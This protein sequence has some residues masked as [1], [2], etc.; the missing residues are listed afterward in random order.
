[1]DIVLITGANSGIGR[2]TAVRLG[3]AGYRVYAAMRDLGK[4][5]KLLDAAAAAGSEVH[6]VAV[7]VTDERSVR[8]G[9]EAVLGEAGRI[10]VLINNAGI[11]LNATT[12][13]I[14]IGVGKAVFD[15]NYWGAIRCLQAVLPQM[16]ERRSGHIV[17]VSS[18]TGRVAAIGQTVYASS[19]WALECM[20]ENLAQ[21]VAGFGIRVSVIEPS[22]TRT[23]MLPKNLAVP[24]HTAYG[25]A[26]QWMLNFYAAGIAA[27]VRPEEVADV[28]REAL[29][30]DEPRFRYPCAWGGDGLVFGRARM[31]DHE[32]IEM[33]A[34]A[35]DEEYYERFE[36]HFGLDIRPSG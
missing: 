15:T 29:A 16:R 9:V 3:A 34:A 17:N 6:I 13:D 33:G 31:S 27:N 4:A 2:A 8:E 26:Y 35:T 21:E 30:T 12:E 25:P 20:S 5:G 1:V 22:V 14:D 10:D 24:E 7:D 36:R 19:K 11:A 18:V 23:A 28:I 32:W